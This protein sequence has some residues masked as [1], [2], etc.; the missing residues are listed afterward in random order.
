MDDETGAAEPVNALGDGYVSRPGQHQHADA[1][2][3]GRRPITG[4]GAE[5]G[6]RQCRRPCYELRR[7]AHAG[8]RVDAS[9]QSP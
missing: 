2:D 8:S 9:V 5:K 6:H 4:N 1:V 7:Q 3:V